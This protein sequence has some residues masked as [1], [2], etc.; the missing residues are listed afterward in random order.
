MTTAKNTEHLI[1]AINCW[2][3]LRGE[4]A[5]AG[6]I[7]RGIVVA[8]TEDGGR[9]LVQWSAGS[10]PTWHGVDELRNGFYPGLV[11][12]DRPFSNTRRTLGTGTVRG[13]RYIAGRDM[14]LVQ[15]HSTGQNLWMPF[16]NLVGL[17]G[18]AT[19][20]IRQEL[21]TPDCHERFRLKAYA[22]ALDAWNQVT[23]ALDR[24]DV[25]PLPHQIDLVHRIMTSDQTNWLI[26]DDVGLGKTIEVGLLLAA[27]RRRRQARRVL[28]VCPAGVVRQWQDEMNYKFN[29]D[30]RIYGFDFNVN[31]PSHWLGND[32]VI[33]SIDRAKSDANLAKILDSGEWDV[34]VF[35]EAHHLSKGSH[36]AATQRFALAQNLR[37]LTDSFVFLTGTPHQ[38]DNVRFVNM[39][40]LLRPDLMQELHR[41]FS[42]PIV[43]SEMVLRNRKSQA[44]DMTG[45]FIFHGQ[46]SYRV[47]VPDTAEIIDFNELLTR[48]VTMGYEAAGRGDG[49][50]RAIGFVM[51][52]YRKL[53]SSSI[54]A[55]DA[56]LRRRLSR[57]QP[58]DTTE[59]FDRILDFSE[60]FDAINEGIDGQDDLDELADAVGVSAG[61]GTPFFESE[62][63]WLERLLQLSERAKHREPKIRLFLEQIADPV[64]SGGNKLLIFTEYR[65][66]QQY[67]VEQLKER[68]PDSGVLQIHGSMTLR[69]KRTNIASFNDNGQF[70]VST[71]AGG[72]GLNLHEACH[73]MVNYDMPW[74][75]GR[76]VQRAGRLYRYG[77]KDRVM[78]FNLSSTENF[79]NRVLT[80]V[81]ERVES[82]ARD[83]ANVS[84]E[85]GDPAALETEIIGQLLERL[86]IAS[87]L[88]ASSTMSV[89]HTDQEIESALERARQA[90][91]QQDRL[92]ATVEGYDPRALASMH[93]FSSE[94]V[95]RFLEGM[96]P[97]FHNIEIRSR[98]YDGRVLEIRLPD[99]LR[100][101]YSEF[102]PGVTVVR[103]CADRQLAQGHD[104]IHLMDFKS[105]FFEALIDYA[106]SPSFGG[107]YAAMTGP[108]RGTLGL[109]RLRWQNDQGVPNRDDIVP[110]FLEHSNPNTTANPD[111]FGSLIANRSDPADPPDTH[112]PAERRDHL[113]LL[114]SA[115]EMELAA[116]CTKFRHPNDVVL[117]AT[118]DIVSNQH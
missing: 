94:D 107:D 114:D 77:Q 111:F 65:A 64:R 104:D 87:I 43:V 41:V 4:R 8:V 80:R 112:T 78:I 83:M 118:A 110:I 28:V 10:E 37:Q 71:E 58:Q 21:T 14:V 103:I 76:L 55:I 50:A 81:L 91:I 100:G 116:Q 44:T 88:S 73:V 62:T 53:A 86:D 59:D 54:P 84:P 31:Q 82:I 47:N 68:F 40:G 98:Q 17:R 27:L 1:P 57:L 38:G 7:R 36:L 109:Y 56:A 23:G 25:D 90:Q 99:E 66:T 48:Y 102:P 93:T 70:L 89:Q 30:F 34:I 18:A 113:R 11:V 61:G 115:A 5:Q 46:D 97:F 26:A 60:Q 6:E 108:R 13:E 3:R 29:E 9:V 79:D 22:Y 33:V 19:R 105:P 12:Q 51:T 49:I 96:L 15:W 24:L 75:P 101:R 42:N 92:F 2:V 69:E 52:T 20:Y 32:K 72:E 95:L 67:I 45:N 106:Q 74:N 85:F 35:D 16:E 63:E 39:L 117:L